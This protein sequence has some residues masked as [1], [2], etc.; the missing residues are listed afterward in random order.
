MTESN[1]I[2]NTKKWIEEV[3]IGCGFCPFA[4]KVFIENSIRYVVIA[5]GALHT[6]S[7]ILLEEIALLESNKKIETTLIIFATAY[8]YFGAY[9]QMLQQSEKLLKRKNHE[10]KYQ[11][12]SF[13]PYY[14]FAGT[15]ENEAS[16]YTNRS[17]YPMLHILREDGL[18][19]AIA[20]YPNA[21]KIPE[22]NIAFAQSKGVEYMRALL[23]NCRGLK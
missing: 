9:W 17:P 16:N 12:A 13:H 18:A 21:E 1:I 3:V 7:G 14:L 8:Q 15:N 2:Q 22:R 23:A 4:R 10:G 5:D 6:H 19:A 20:H 11:L